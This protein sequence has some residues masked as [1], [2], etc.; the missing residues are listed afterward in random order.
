M[1]Q[2]QMKVTPIPTSFEHIY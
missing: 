2:K 1:F